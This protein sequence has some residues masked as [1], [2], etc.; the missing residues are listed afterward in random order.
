MHSK[1]LSTET[2]PDESGIIPA[3]NR[4]DWSFSRTGTHVASPHSLHWFP[5][6]FIPQIPAFLIQILSSPGQIICDPFAGSGTTGFEAAI[7]HRNSLQL[8]ANSA[9][10]MI[11]RAK[12]SLGRES[13]LTAA[14]TSFGQQIAWQQR[15][16]TVGA[17][18]GELAN[19]LHQSTL[20]QLEDIATHIRTVVDS[21]VTAVL[22]TVLSDT[23]FAC[24]APRNATTRTGRRRRHHWGWIADNVILADPFPHDAISLFLDRLGDTIDIAASIPRIQGHHSVIQAD[25]RQIPL[26]AESVDHVVTSPPYLGMIDYARANRLTYSWFGWNLGREMQ[27]E[28]GARFKR[29]RRACEAEYIGAMSEVAAEITRVLRVGGYCAIVIGSSRRFPAASKAVIDMFSQSLATVWG[30]VS[31]VPTRRRV[32]ERHG[33]EPV[34][35][36]CIYR[37]ES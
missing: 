29:G 28:I 35:Y 24:S 4:V 3:L 25:A 36:I 31:R 11:A 8:D 20:L 27:A 30:P 32:S 15:N 17:N 1:P 34:E 19:W 23:L 21:D 7:L 14:L 16:K 37:K 5:G 18:R 10:V 13:K 33:T 22:N 26:P 2:A 9:A 12:L 6:N